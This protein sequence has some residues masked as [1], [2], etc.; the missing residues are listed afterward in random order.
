MVVVGIG[1][2]WCVVRLTWLV[3]PLG[4]GSVGDSWEH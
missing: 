2:D 4:L 1:W 3:I